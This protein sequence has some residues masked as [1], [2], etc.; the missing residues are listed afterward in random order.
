VVIIQSI[1]VVAL[2]L[3]RGAHFPGGFAG[4]VVLIGCSIL[5]AVP[6]GT[7]SNGIALMLRHQESVIAVSQ[8]VLLPLT[9]L[10]STFMAQNLMPGWM[11]DVASFN[12]VSWSVQ[13][14]RVAL[15]AQADWGYVLTRVG[16]LVAL[17]VVCG[18]FS[19]MAF[20]SYQKS[21]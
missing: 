10:S 19:V 12:P 7:L 15:Q 1:I 5:L 14:S 11:Q 9:F 18:W 20:K 3:L 4:V 8:F 17:T 21:V 16:W 6:F 13:A 2:G